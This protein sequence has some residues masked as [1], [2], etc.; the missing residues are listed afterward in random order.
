MWAPSQPGLHKYPELWSTEPLLAETVAVLPVTGVGF[1]D[2][3]R[4]LEWARQ[5]EGEGD[6]RCGGVPI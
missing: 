6:G 1:P 5:E 4:R 3:W 2:N